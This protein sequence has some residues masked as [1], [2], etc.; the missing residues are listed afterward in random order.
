MAWPSKETAR[1]Y[2]RDYYAKN[3]DKLREYFR[4]WRM[5]N[6]EQEQA[7]S[8]IK[9]QKTKAICSARAKVRYEMKGHEIRTN[10]KRRYQ[11]DK[12][13]VLIR[14][15]AWRLKRDFGLTVQEYNDIHSMQKGLCAICKKKS[16]RRLG[17]DH[18][19]TTGKIRGLLSHSCNIALGL[20]KDCIASAE[21]LV[22]YLKAAQQ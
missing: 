20:L 18:C 15:R 16:K 4:I 13:R 12:E 19:H 21:S 22:S 6:K 17:V 3:K 2:S 7:R 10:N 14:T 9:Y 1:A 11:R 8:R 5:K